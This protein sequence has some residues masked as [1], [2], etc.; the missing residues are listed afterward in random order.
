[1]NF[2]IVDDEMNSLAIVSG[3]GAK[4]VI[5]TDQTQQNDPRS[6]GGL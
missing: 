3:E 2:T 5:G 4:A 1:M 6:R